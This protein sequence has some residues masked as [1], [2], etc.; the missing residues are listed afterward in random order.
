MD[1]GVKNKPV[2]LRMWVFFHTASNGQSSFYRQQ[3][4]TQDWDVDPVR[5]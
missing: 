2:S 5:R 1:L 4:H 3:N